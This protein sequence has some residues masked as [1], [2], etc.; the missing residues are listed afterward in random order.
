MSFVLACVRFLIIY[1]RHI[2]IPYFSIFPLNYFFT[3]FFLISLRNYDNRKCFKNNFSLFLCWFDFKFK[4]F[5]SRNFSTSFNETVV[6]SSLKKLIFNEK[7]FSFLGK[8]FEVNFIM[9]HN[10]LFEKLFAKGAQLNHYQ[11]FTFR[12]L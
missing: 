10:F 11:C 7:V 2:L 3:I 6:K 8:L 12:F 9:I 5:P 1:F 4:L